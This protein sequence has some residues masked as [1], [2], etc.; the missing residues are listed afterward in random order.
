[1][2]AENNRKR[3][4]VDPKRYAQFLADRE[5]YP[6]STTRDQAFAMAQERKLKAWAAV[7]GIDFGTMHRSAHWKEGPFQFHVKIDDT[8]TDSATEIGNAVSKVDLIHLGKYRVRPWADAATREREK[9]EVYMPSVVRATGVDRKR[10][11]HQRYR[12]HQYACMPRTYQDCFDGLW[13]LGHDKATCDRMARKFWL[14][15]YVRFERHGTHWDFVAVVVRVDVDLSGDGK[16]M[17]RGEH[18]SL[19]GIESDSDDAYFLSTLHELYERALGDTVE[20]HKEVLD[21]MGI[22]AP[23][24][25]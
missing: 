3:P 10:T 25:A 24:A 4:E 7:R 2:S 21:T 23:V 12:G 5:K 20:R 8:D 11:G 1:M 15:E 18:D 16:S 19:C 14:D 22:K 6:F 9:R 13:E 17:L